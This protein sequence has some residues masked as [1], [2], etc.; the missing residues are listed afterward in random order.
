M[1]RK[2]LETVAYV[3]LMLEQEF[4]EQKFKQQM[5]LKGICVTLMPNLF[6]IS[7]QKTDVNDIKD[8]SGVL[9]YWFKGFKDFI[10]I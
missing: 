2:I 3:S 1:N 5:D 8:L 10:S 4:I 6:R 7:F 9:C